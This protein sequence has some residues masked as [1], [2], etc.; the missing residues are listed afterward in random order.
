[1]KKLIQK[2]KNCFLSWEVY[3][4]HAMATISNPADNLMHRCQSSSG[5]RAEVAGRWYS[6]TRAFTWLIFLFSLAS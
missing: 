4:C 2:G 5:T 3:K 6:V 1:M